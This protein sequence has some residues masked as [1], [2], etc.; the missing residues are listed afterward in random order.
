MSYILLES[1]DGGAVGLTGLP[2]VVIY[3]RDLTATIDLTKKTSRSGGRTA[4]EWPEMV[5]LVQ[6]VL[7]NFRSMRLNESTS[8][9]VFACHAGTIPF[10]LMLKDNVPDS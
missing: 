7:N 8:M 2:L 1:I 6:S 4:D 10:T 3:L 9:Q 5:N